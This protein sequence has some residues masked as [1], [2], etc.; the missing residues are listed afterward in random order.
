MW[1]VNTIFKSVHSDPLFAVHR[2]V[3]IDVALILTTLG[4]AFWT[5]DLQT[6]LTWHY[7]GL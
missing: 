6:V 1:V 5:G 2:S 7:F 4:F 3:L